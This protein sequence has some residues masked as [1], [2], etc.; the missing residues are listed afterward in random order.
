MTAELT[1]QDREAALA[2]LDRIERTLSE[3]SEWVDGDSDARER[4]AIML[5]DAAKAVMAAAWTLTRDAYRV[6][7]LVHR[8]LPPPPP[9]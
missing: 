1:R 2:E 9:G 4:C 5:E 8:R 3:M 7:E 6:S